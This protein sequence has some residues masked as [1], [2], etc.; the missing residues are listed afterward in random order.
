MQTQN[1]ETTKTFNNYSDV[2]EYFKTHNEYPKPG[3]ELHKFVKSQVEKYKENK[4]KSK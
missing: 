3:G 1:N 4:P 2:I